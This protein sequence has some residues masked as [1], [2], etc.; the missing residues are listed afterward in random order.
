MPVG[1]RARVVTY[2]QS[3]RKRLRNATTP[4]LA[5]RHIRWSRLP[6]LGR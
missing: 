5:V 4:G 3:M 1:S 6:Y 2:T